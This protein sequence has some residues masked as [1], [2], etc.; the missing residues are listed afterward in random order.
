[1]RQ[2]LLWLQLPA[3]LLYSWRRLNF[4]PSYLYLHSAG[5]TVTHQCTQ[6]VWCRALCMEF[7]TLPTS[8]HS[9]AQTLILVMKFPGHVSQMPFQR[10]RGGGGNSNSRQ[11]R[12]GC[13]FL[14]SCVNRHWTQLRKKS[15]SYSHATFKSLWKH[16]KSATDLILVKH[17]VS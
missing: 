7:S 4:W 14:N 5:F 2:S 6:L 9:S 3:D 15:D 1:M 17:P 11:D 13:D 12:Y 16:P 10:T 8:L